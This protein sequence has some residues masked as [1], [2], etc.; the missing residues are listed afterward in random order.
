ME[1]RRRLVEEYVQEVYTLKLE[2]Q[3]Q[4]Q[5]GRLRYQSGISG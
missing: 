5:K 2:H 4:L 3:Q 1:A